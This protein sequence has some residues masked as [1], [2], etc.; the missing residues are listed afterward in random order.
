MSTDTATINITAV[1]DAHVATITPV[2]YAET[3]QTGL[4]L[5]NAG[6]AISD[7]DAGSGS[8]TVTLAVSDGALALIGGSLVAVVKTCGIP[9]VTITGTVAQV[10]DLLNTNASSTVSYSDNTD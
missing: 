10:N 7:A 3:E 1:N 9:S 4:T 6:L 5:K 2:S 8:M